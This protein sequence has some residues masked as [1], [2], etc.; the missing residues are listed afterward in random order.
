[1][2]NSFYFLLLLGLSFFI[3]KCKSV[4]TIETSPLGKVTYPADN[5]FDSL[6]VALGEKLFFDF[7]LSSDENVS[8]ASCHKPGLAFTDGKAVSDGVEGRK[9]ARNSPSILNSAFLTSLMYDGEL[10]N[11]E[12]QAIVPI[13]DHNEMDMDMKTLIEKLRKVP[14][15]Q[16]AA[17]K[18]FKRDFDPYVL[19]RSISAYER[20][21][22]SDDSDFDLFYYKN[23]KRKLN[24]SEQRGFQIFSQKLYCTQCHSL[25]YFTTFKVE[26][27]GYTTLD[28][29]DLGRF[30]I[31]G[32]S[33]D[34]GKFKVPSLRNVDITG[35]Y[36][37][38]GKFETLE[39]VVD[40]YAK[41]GRKVYNQSKIIQPF[42]LNSQEK[43]DLINF[44][45]SLTGNYYK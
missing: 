34:I 21:L 29:E 42:T 28:S 24:K 13:Q 11:L 23:K 4:S 26:N 33:N 12:M 5:E 16:E 15:Y 1:M 30:R 32:D 44:L 10:K 18:I 19:S 38:D 35:P 37:H 20:T 40:F 31:H 41:G 6:K 45:I 36:M 43:E 27:N 8:C 22:I 14:E 2:K 3:V 9:T 39:E 7:R 25:P 17:Q